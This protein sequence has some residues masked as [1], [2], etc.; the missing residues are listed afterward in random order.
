MRELLRKEYCKNVVVCQ[1]D[2]FNLTLSSSW[3]FLN[4]NFECHPNRA[5]SWIQA[6]S[7]LKFREIS[8]ISMVP[9]N[10]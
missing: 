5:Q 10:Y 4:E 7:S 8:F 9:V 6:E 2:Q 1:K 3:K